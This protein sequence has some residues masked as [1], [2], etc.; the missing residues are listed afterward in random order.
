MIRTEK[1]L[2][3][4]SALLIA[5][6]ALIWGN[7][8]LPA[9]L[10]AAISGWLRELLRGI[11]GGASS[12]LGQGDGLLRKIAHFA[13]FGS[14][15][16]LLCWRLGM[17]KKPAVLALLGGFA[18]ACMDETIQIFVPGRGPGVLDVVIDTCGVAC[19]ILL[20]ILGHNLYKLIK[21]END[22]V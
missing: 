1:R 3:I 9:E 15:G 20:L 5:N 18:A 10:S 4:C 16:L 13:E 11:F 22:S 19:G 21:N 14:L 8:L 7:S 17:Q 2:Q 6:L 12:G